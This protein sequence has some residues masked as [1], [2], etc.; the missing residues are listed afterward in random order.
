MWLGQKSKSGCRHKSPRVRRAIF[1][2]QKSRIKRIQKNGWSEQISVVYDVLQAHQ[3]DTKKRWS[4]Q[5]SVAYDVLQARQT[6]TKNGWSKPPHPQKAAI[7]T[8]QPYNQ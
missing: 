7:S 5:I 3:T 4:E 8:S 2:I 1:K 6:D